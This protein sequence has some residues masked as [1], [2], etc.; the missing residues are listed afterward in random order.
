MTTAE[1]YIRAVDNAAD[2]AEAQVVAAE[3]KAVEEIDARYRGENR[4]SD[5]WSAL[6]V[7]T[8]L[9]MGD[10]DD[11]LPEDR[12]IDWTLGVAGIAAAS[13]VD[14]WLTDRDDLLIKPAAY[15]EQVVGG[16]KISGAELIRA[17]KRG[18]EVLGTTK[19][20]KLRSDVL[21]QFKFLKEM[22]SVELYRTLLEAGAMRTP[23]KIISDSMGY[24]SRMTSY[25]PGS[26]QFVEQVNN[27]ISQSSKRGLKGMT[28]RAVQQTYTETEVAG[29]S[30]RDMVWIVEGGKNTCGY[31]LDRAGM[32]L[33]YF[34]WVLE[35]LPGADVCLGGDLCRCFLAAV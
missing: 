1:E 5:L 30:D 17:G 9:T 4:D 20:E 22:D 32:V 16:L 23:D 33:P 3:Q 25:R 13:L 26:T 15:Q 12:D 7:D 2:Y 31:C 27:L 14:F 6:G 8:D 29:K 18:F 28:R 19:Y 21:A 35:G 11:A 10:Y 24:V 34:Q